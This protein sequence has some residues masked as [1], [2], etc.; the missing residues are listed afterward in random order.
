MNNSRAIAAYWVATFRGQLDE[1][2]LLIFDRSLAETA[3]EDAAAAIDEIAAAGGYPPTPQRIAELA[4]PHRRQRALERIENE[5][6][7]LRDANRPMS[8]RDWHEN[9]AIDAEKAIV[10]KVAPTLRKLLEEA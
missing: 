2:E 8:F 6:R 9:V 3:V 1:P 4:E 7:A 10:T 5:A